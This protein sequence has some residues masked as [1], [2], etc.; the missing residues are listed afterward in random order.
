MP[1]TEE[2]WEPG[3]GDSKNISAFWKYVFKYSG[4]GTDWGMLNRELVKI[5]LRLRLVTQL[6]DFFQ[7]KL[8]EYLETE[9]MTKS[10]E[11]LLS[12]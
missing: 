8:K 6:R 5:K 1:K 3:D 4:E 9:N 11:M 7:Y 10:R 12:K 2:E